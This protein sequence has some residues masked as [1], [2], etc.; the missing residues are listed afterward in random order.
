MSLTSAEK[1]AAAEEL[2]AAGKFEDAEFLLEQVLDSHPL[3]VTALNAR[4]GL[5]MRSGKIQE[6]KRLLQ[7][8][9]D[10]APDDPVVLTNLANV[11]LL[12]NRIPEAVD[13]LER[14]HGARPDYLAAILLLG[15]VHQMLGQR[16]AAADWLTRASALQ[17]EDP[18]VLAA[19]AAFELEQQNFAE[20]HR[21]YDKALATRPGHLRSLAGL[22]RLRCLS[23]EFDRAL[24]L[25]E[26]AH[27]LAPQD[28]EI[29]LALAQ[30]YLQSGALSD[31]AKLMG[32]F[33]RRYADY[34]PVI[35]LAAEIRIALGEVQ[36]GLA[37][38]AAWFRKAPGDTTRLIAFLK[39]LKKAGDW[40]R[41]LD[42]CAKLPPEI[43]AADAVV[44]LCEEALLALGQVDEGWRSWANRRNLP[45]E[46]PCAPLQVALPPR[47]P[48]LDELVMMRFVDVIARE[49]AVELS[50]ETPVAGL[51]DHLVAADSIRWLSD[52]SGD[53]PVD[54][55]LLADL[56]AQTVLSAP[57]KAAFRPYLAPDRQRRAVWDAAL[58][59]DGRP[60]VGVFW[61]A[62]APGFLIDH[63]REALAGV[64][65][66]LVSLQFDESRHQL[67]SWPGVL[68][69]GVK[70]DGLG[71]L[72]NLV[73]CLDLIVG[74]DGIPLHVAGALGCKGVA[75]LQE[76]HD[77]YWAGRG[78]SS[79]WYP[80]VERLVVPVGP[81]WS[82]GQAEL[83]DVLADLTDGIHQPVTT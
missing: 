55:P 24:E 66:H 45:L 74:P 22:A 30:V 73:D 4:C 46:D 7:I 56:T 65:C 28:P 6:A 49:G 18:D 69:A 83:R 42:M 62:R 70:L 53:P 23:G 44:S 3:Q 2:I 72:V 43:Q 79:L 39:L 20:A 75:V 64:D 41:I 27:L 37:E 8:A 57:D 81:G 54:A 34:A 77:W 17:P 40:Q 78:R 51:W 35:L 59:A 50:G 80:S 9:Q 52:P 68:D 82:G 19:G 33:R 25:A 47:A 10:V 13:A 63:L 26:K 21:L 61:N 32:R 38:A 12:E 60:R 58:P 48:L 71:D 31:A 14:A 36:E 29:A 76:N 16:Q 5:L 67:R 11:A 15:Q 1:C